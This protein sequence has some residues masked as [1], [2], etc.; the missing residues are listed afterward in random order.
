[1]PGPLLAVLAAALLGA[2]A[3]P[4]RSSPAPV[5]V[6]SPAPRPAPAPASAP[7]VRAGAERVFPAPAIASP[8]RPS[9]PVVFTPLPTPIVPAAIAARFPEP[10]VTFATPAFEP[11]RTTFTGND[12]LRAILHGLE[13]S[14]T[15]GEHASEV[16]VLPLG[17]SQVGTP[18][19]ALA[20]TR[21][22]APPAL[23][24][25]APAVVGAPLRRPTVVVVAAQHG[26]E[27]A[28]TEALI[29]VAQELAA[30]R[31]AGV[32]DRVDVVLLPRANPDG[33]AAFTRGAADGTDV[34]RDHLLLQTPEARAIAQL[35][36][37]FAPIVVLDLHEYPVG[38]AFTAK[39][40][41]VQRFDALLQ[42]ATTA[43]MAP[44]VTKAAEEWFRLP[45]VAGLRSAGLSADWYAT[46]SADPADK[47][48]S[49]GSVGPQVGRNASGLRHAVSLLVETRGGGLGRVD[50]KRRVQSQVVATT[51]VLASAA[52]H[53]D[54]LTK[55]RQF[56]DRETASF[57]CQGQVVVE[58]APTPSEYAYQLIDAVSGEIRHINV[59][60]ESALQLRT[61]KS[62]PRPCGYWLAPGQS[63]AV[64]RLRLLGVEVQQLDELGELRGEAY[65]EVGREA[66]AG[67]AAANAGGATRLKVQM[68]P[69]LLDVAAG[70]YYVSLEQPL[71]HLAVAVLEPEAPAS[72]A[73]NGVIAD[74]GGEARILLRP[75]IRMTAVP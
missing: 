10:A 31:L 38:G 63:D 27:P 51:N 59:A 28:G 55:L 45:L 1:M 75:A 39:F 36:A 30:G 20:F 18:I 26:D 21:P 7:P 23:A 14:A 42:Y 4:Q 32:L 12:E 34:N 41:G 48:L 24:G 62:R 47:T 67:G 65:R 56:V 57:A 68:Q 11:N 46:V 19:E 58:A 33:A 54:D 2:C 5:V 6:L 74:L 53:A 40:G 72:F 3:L 25:A 73:A 22:P 15:I 61:L 70:G 17:V 29:V 35:L 52:R 60:W 44:F 13:R 43:N 16:A 64:R 8:V 50:L 9:P 69:A 71:A 37:S 66:V 49:M